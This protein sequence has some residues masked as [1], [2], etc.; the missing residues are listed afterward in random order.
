MRTRTRLLFAGLTAAL[1]LSAAVSTASGSRL[2]TN[3]TRFRTVWT[4]LALES[5]QATISCPVTLEGS[6]HSSTIAKVANAL[7]GRVSRASV[8][9]ALAAGSCTGGSATINQASLPWHI[10]FKVIKGALPRFEAILV[11][12]IGVRFTVDP[13]SGFLP[14]CNSTTTIENPAVGDIQVEANGLVTGL[15]AD[16][17]AEIPLEGGFCAFGGSG[18]FSGTGRVSRLGNTTNIRVTLI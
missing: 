3:E 4:N 15:R 16:E 1:L 2:S 10:T 17:T 6:F 9:G 11:N 12:L 5:S 18:H 13:L 8:R 14:A 7:I